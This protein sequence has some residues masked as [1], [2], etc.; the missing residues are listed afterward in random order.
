MD[1]LSLRDRARVRAVQLFRPGGAGS[2][3]LLARGR[4]LERAHTAKKGFDLIGK[5]A[6]LPGPGSRASRSGQA[7]ALPRSAMK[8]LISSKNCRSRTLLARADEVI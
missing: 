2:A 3:R 5:I 4:S 8:L 1:A 6:R 7:T